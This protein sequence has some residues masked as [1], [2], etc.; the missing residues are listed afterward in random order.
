MTQ[1][2]IIIPCYNA[3][4][5]LP[6]T[7]N[8]IQAQTHTDW[9]V[10]CIDDG[11]TDETRAVIERYAS[12]DRRIQLGVSDRQGP[13]VARNLGALDWAMGQVIAFCDADDIWTPTKLE[14]LA[15]SFADKTVDA[16]YG[17]IAFFKNDPT[18]ISTV[19]TVPTGD[20]TIE[21]LLAEN[22]VCTMSVS[23]T[24]LTLPTTS[25]V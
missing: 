21:M 4:S 10:L 14:E 19:S 13:S 18:E 2:S 12:A 8:A 25:R 6:E 22:P 11:S 5:T 23:Y 9:E 1:F 15:T 20:L 7:L 24:H 16:V 17:Q 3:A